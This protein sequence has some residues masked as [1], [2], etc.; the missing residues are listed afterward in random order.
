MSYYS[1]NKQSPN[2]SFREAVIRGLAPDK[3]LYYPATIR[4]LDPDFLA[5]ID[6]YTEHEIA[7]EVISPFVG[8]SIPKE[9]L[10]A[11]IKK[12][13]S[14]DFP[15]I[16][17][18]DQIATLELF[19]GPTMAFKDVGARF[20]ANCLGYFNQNLMAISPHFI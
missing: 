7:L 9:V 13:L 14:F 6:R 12:T 10:A 11:I 15:V 1:L 17:I 2:V 20:M 18:E 19:H 8:D 16:P 5:N 3:G 4:K